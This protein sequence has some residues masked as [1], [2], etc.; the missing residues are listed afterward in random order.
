MAAL[1][2][3]FGSPKTATIQEVDVSG[4]ITDTVVYTIS[5]ELDVV[6]DSTPT[7][8]H[9]YFYTTKDYQGPVDYSETPDKVYMVITPQLVTTTPGKETVSVTV[10]GTC[11]AF[12]GQIPK[13]K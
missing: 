3:D 8:N 11:G 4:K 5:I 12:K 1:T 10:T 6:D 13:S 9:R 7:P 2:A